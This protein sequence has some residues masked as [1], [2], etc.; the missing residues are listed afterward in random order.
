MN[1]ERLSESDLPER[2]PR[3]PKFL[4]FLIMDMPVPPFLLRNRR[5]VVLVTYAAITAF[6]YLIA[7]LLRFEFVISAKSWTIIKSTI[8]LLVIVRCVCYYVFGTTRARLRF[9]GSTDFARLSAATVGGSLIFAGLVKLMGNVVVPRSIFA[10][11]WGLTTYLTATLLLVYRTG[12]EKLRFMRHAVGGR[13]TLIVGAG[14]AGSMLAREMNRFPTGYRPVAFL[15][16]D[17]E[18]IGTTVQGLRVI[19]SSDNITEVARMTRADDIVIATPSAAPE[20]LRRIVSLCEETDL[21]FKVLPG[22]AEVIAGHVSQTQIRDLRIEDLLG[23]EPVTLELPELRGDLAGRS[24]LITGA[25][26]SIGSELARQ[27]ALHQPGVLV[28]LDQAETD[29]FYLELEL[30]EKFPDLQIVMRIA[31]VVDPIAIDRVFKMYTPSRV[32][33]AAAYK[34]V[35][36]MQSNPRQAIRNNVQGTW[37]VAD[38]AGRH[39]CDKFVLVSTDK[40]VEPTS[41]MG[42]TKRLAEISVLE[43]QRRYPE[44]LFAGVRFGNVLASA[45]SVIPIFQRLIQQNKP[46]TVTHPEVTRYF[47]TISEAVQLI[48]QASLLPEVRGQIAMLEMGEPVRITDLARN[49]LRLSGLPFKVGHTVVFTGMRPG[50]KLH[51]ELFAYDET[52]SPTSIPKVKVVTPSKMTISDVGGL[53]ATWEEAFGESRDSDVLASLTSIFPGLHGRPAAL[54][55]SE[56]LAVR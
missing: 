51:E 1:K 32:F 56:S 42:A 19:A 8:P 26:G 12:F 55:A 50:E 45:G 54:R 24:V 38:S 33:H 46:L 53:L 47:M 9:A 3:V 17:P 16:D 36:M 21:S 15:D 23:R 5:S 11:E 10:L 34:H 2:F 22:I 13:R 39:G 14:E 37:Q 18:K 49:I 6:A 25:A 52:T 29:L 40:A 48:L 28:L 31:D 27:V 30:R 43:M 7:F 4:S 44:T 20:D 35:P 41:V